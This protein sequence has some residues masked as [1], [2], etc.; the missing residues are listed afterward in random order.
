MSLRDLR[1]RIEESAVNGD[2][3][4]VVKDGELCDLLD[5]L[6]AVE[7][8]SDHYA[9]YPGQVSEASQLGKAILAV[10]NRF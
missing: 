8:L 3:R 5:L 10:C 9:L 7:R 1:T 2:V 4:I 6:N